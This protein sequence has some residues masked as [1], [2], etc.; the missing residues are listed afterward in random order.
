[1]R[2]TVKLDWCSYDLGGFVGTITQHAA[3]QGLSVST[4][5][6]R[7]ARGWRLSEALGY[8]E[9]KRP[10]PAAPGRAPKRLAAEKKHGKP[11][12]E[13]LRDLH[14]DGVS[15]AGAARELDY[16]ARSFARML[17]KYPDMNFWKGTGRL[18]IRAFTELHG[19]DPAE[20]LKKNAASYT[21][22]GAAKFIGYS[23]PAGLADFIA[24]RR[25][26]VEFMRPGR[27]V[28]Y[29]GKM[30]NLDGH[31]ARAG[32]SR[33][34]LGARIHRGMSIEKALSM[35]IKKNANQSKEHQHE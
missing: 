5:R 30:D 8:T 23:H 11:F 34:T 26:Q 29:R 7:K 17:A 13:I 28:V 12:V 1:M 25:L 16:E 19:V 14:A 32:I 15:Q 6:S 22:T 21:M 2:G 24:S 18:V 35:P 4:V 10:M 31:A 3:R 9:H 33:G 27:H 20:W